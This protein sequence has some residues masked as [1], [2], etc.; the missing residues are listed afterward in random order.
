MTRR[1]TDAANTGVPV[2]PVLS[3]RRDIAGDDH[4]EQVLSPAVDLYKRFLTRTGDR[5]HKHPT[6]WLS[7]SRARHTVTMP[8]RPEELDE[9][10]AAV[11]E[12]AGGRVRPDWPAAATDDA[13]TRGPHRR[14]V[15]A[16]HDP[17]GPPGPS[18]ARDTRAVPGRPN[19]THSLAVEPD[20][21]VAR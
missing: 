5:Q 18:G 17:A 15:P 19:P 3:E 2:V 11:A 7:P 4:D 13:T 21:R 8:E 12:A 1:Y 9:L 10:S 14:G 16:R 6:R 20:T